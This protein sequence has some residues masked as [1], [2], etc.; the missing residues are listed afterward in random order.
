MGVNRGKQFEEQIKKA[1][2]RYSDTFVSID[3]FPDPSAGYAG[4][5]NICDFAVYSYPYM[6]YLECKSVHGNTL[7]FNNITEN[8]WNGLLK[9]G[10]L[11]GVAA[12]IL[13][14]FIDRDVTAFVPIQEFQRLKDEGYKS[15]NVKQINA[16]E[17]QHE[18]IPG[19]KKRVLYE[20]NISS[21]LIMAIG[22]KYGGQ[23]K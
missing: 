15:L 11:Y 16:N 19:Q 9:K 7:N 8:Q 1:F 14:W 3:R 4:V 12:G 23:R 6:L 10:T 22:G 21:R 20:Y 18:I 2:E 5:K 17:V 13:V